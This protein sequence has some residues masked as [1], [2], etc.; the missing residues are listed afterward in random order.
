VAFTCP[1]CGRTSHHPED[2]RQGYCGACHDW[3]LAAEYTCGACLLR[4]WAPH[5]LPGPVR[6][7]CG[8]PEPASRASAHVTDVSADGTLQQ[9][10]GHTDSELWFSD[11]LTQAERE[12]AVRYIRAQAGAGAFITSSHTDYQPPSPERQL[13]VDDHHWGDAAAWHPGY[14][15]L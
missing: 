15:E 4:F 2:E 6:C 11:A 1:R 5:A 3:T 8:S 13:Q 14:R 12:A 9:Y 10:L 7:R